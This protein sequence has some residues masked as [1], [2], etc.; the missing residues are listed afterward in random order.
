MWTLV[1]L[2]QQG[3]TEQELLNNYPGFTLENLNPAIAKFRV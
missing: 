1:P 2:R 3:G